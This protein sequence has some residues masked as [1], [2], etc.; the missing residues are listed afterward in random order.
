MYA[1]L[2]QRTGSDDPRLVT[3]E[4]Q[5]DRATVVATRSRVGEGNSINMSRGRFWI[6][7]GRKTVEVFLP[8]TA[9]DVSSFD[10]RVV[11]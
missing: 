5:I 9:G 11:R 8:L 1:R 2:P 6:A 4:I 3:V 7:D 10:V